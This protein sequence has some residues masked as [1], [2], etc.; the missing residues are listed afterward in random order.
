MRA[1]WYED[2]RLIPLLN[3]CLT[4][5]KVGFGWNSDLGRRYI[6]RFHPLKGLI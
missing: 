1:V 3:S 6:S 5:G 2:G 4:Y